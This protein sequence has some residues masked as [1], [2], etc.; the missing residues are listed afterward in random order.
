MT[1]LRDWGASRSATITPP[2]Q[3]LQ[4][5]LESFQSLQAHLESGGR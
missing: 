5:H 3:S 2:F 1:V 4:A